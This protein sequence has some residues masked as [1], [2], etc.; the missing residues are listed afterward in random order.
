MVGRI[1]ERKTLERLLNS[2]ESEFLAIYGRR[3]VGKTYLVRETFEG[4]FAFEH[5]GAANTTNRRQLM[6][7]FDSL[8]KHGYEGR[9]SPKNWFGAF[10]MLSQTLAAKECLQRKIVFIDEL[11][12]MDAPKSDFLPALEYFW[13]SWAAAR[14]DVFFIICGSAA[15]WIVKCIFKNK[16]GLHNR[17][18]ARICLQPFT[19][20]E[21]EKLAEENG[22]AMSR[23]DIAE[24]YMALGGI[25]YYWRNLERGLSL[26]QNFDK[27]FFAKGALLKTEFKE[28]YSSLF[29]NSELYMKI[30]SALAMRKS[31]LLQAEVSAA[32]GT[33]LSGK[34]SAALDILEESGFIRTY[35]SFGKR[36]RGRFY[37][38][39]DNFTLFHFRFL[40][41]RTD[42]DSFWTSTALSSVQAVW[43]GLAFERLCLQHVQQ[44]RN[45]L[46]IRGVHM[47]TYGW[48]HEGNDVYPKGVQIDLIL[49]RADGIVNIC[50]MKYSK[51][52]YPI[53][54]DVA[55][56]LIRKA[57]TFKSVTGTNKA[58]HITLVTSKGIAA[59]TYA[60]TIQSQITLD[61]LFG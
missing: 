56:E 42:D 18:T 26:A 13:N 27:L 50:E 31:G 40:E 15:S 29:R 5:T 36:K 53:D 61:D 48:R 45:A 9:K 34:I 43:R 6:L 7:F 22:L 14:K 38:L 33:R 59:N 54:S 35:R 57:E 11:P 47:E 23:M 2:Q 28:L 30:V 46:G 51:G 17:V 3:R 19:L 4:R 8:K 60:N 39:I 1:E 49:D 52:E 37:Q 21:C 10:E 44:M 12:W 24:C 32:L 58:V 25:P 20:G 41:G 16:G 55:N